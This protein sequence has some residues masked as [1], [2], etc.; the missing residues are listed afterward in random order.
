MNN[1]VVDALIIGGGPAG[2]SASLPIIRQQFTVVI[3]DNGI[4]PI[5]DTKLFHLIPSW[6]HRHKD[7]FA[8]SAKENLLSRYRTLRFQQTTVRSVRKADTGLFLIEDSDGNQWTGKK[9]ILANGVRYIFPDVEGFAQCWGKGIYRCCFCN[10]FEDR[11]VGSV[12]VLAIDFFG[13]TE[14]AIHAATDFK[15]FAKTV[16]VY[17]NG[18]DDLADK[19][20]TQLPSTRMKIMRQRITRLEKTGTGGEV[21][22]HLD[23]GTSRV[24]GFLG[25]IPSTRPNGTFVED[26]GLET[27]ASGDIKVFPPL[28]STSLHGVYAAGDLCSLSKIASHA[29]YLGNI[30]GAGVAEELLVESD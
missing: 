12:G 10:A 9:V 14:M 23:D 16:M 1:S 15:R 27:E 24:E 26:L 13:S 20:A 2:L 21:T 25:H 22:V 3:F 8:S 19:L 4:S 30:A 29:F 28:N 5:D 11:G 17:T 7:E 6:D 18:S